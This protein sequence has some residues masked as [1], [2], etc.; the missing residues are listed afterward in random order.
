MPVSEHH[1]LTFES[2]FSPWADDHECSWIGWSSESRA[3]QSV[4]GETGEASEGK[5]DHTEE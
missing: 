2:D 5:G 1:I 4:T 3:A